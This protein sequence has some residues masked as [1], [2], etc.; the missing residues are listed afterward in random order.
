MMKWTEDEKPLVTVATPGLI[1]HDDESIW[2]ILVYHDE[3]IYSVCASSAY[4]GDD[5]FEIN[6]PTKIHGPNLE[7]V[8]TAIEALVAAGAIAPTMISDK[9]IGQKLFGDRWETL[10]ELSKSGRMLQ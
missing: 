10:L 9:R 7:R 2:A 5:N 4:E 8:K 3:D 1:L 6:F